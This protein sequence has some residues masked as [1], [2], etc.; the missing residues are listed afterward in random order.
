MSLRISFPEEKVT[1]ENNIS[2]VSQSLFKAL[3][4]QVDRDMIVYE[5]IPDKRIDVYVLLTNDEWM[6]V[7]VPLGRLHSSSSYIFILWVF[8]LSILFFTISL[9]FMRNQIRPILRLSVAAD[10]LGKGQDIVDLKPSGA[11]EVRLAAE[12]FNKMRDR[13]MRQVQHRTSMLAGVSHDLRT[14][15]TRLKLQLAMMGDG[16]DQDAMKQDIEDME[17]MIE[18]YLSFARGDSGET[19]QA[20]DMNELVEEVVT[21]A[22]RNGFEI[23]YQTA[24][25]PIIMTVKQNAM[26]RA[27]SNV[28]GNAAKFATEAQVM[29]MQDMGYVKIL[30]DDN[31]P[32]I[33][34]DKREDVFRPFHR[35]EQ[36]RNTQSGGVGLGLSITQDII[37]SHGGT[38]QLG[39]SSVGGLSVIITL[40]V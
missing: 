35:L 32:G 38:I 10:R 27:L 9:I 5:F 22:R 13:I 25:D 30:I 40:P 24:S 1:T 29:L 6:R 11:R 19:A 34:A 33:P 8:G 37:S 17:V 28:L 36:S 39:E 14:P 16:P 18:G 23:S 31:G 21:N 20:T 3:A 15:L 26:E 4:H 12:A 7:V 2:S